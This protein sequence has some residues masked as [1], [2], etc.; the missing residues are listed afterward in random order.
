MKKRRNLKEN[1]IEVEKGKNM[2]E[3]KNLSGG[4]EENKSKIRQ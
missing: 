1:R 3:W 4:G 2:N